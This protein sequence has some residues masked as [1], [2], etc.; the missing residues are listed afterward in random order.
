MFRSQVL[1]SSSHAIHGIARAAACVAVFSSVVFGGLAFAQ[2]R[3][4][5]SDFYTIET[6][7]I[8]PEFYLEVGAIEFLPDGR[9]A[10]SSRRGDVVMFHDPLRADASEI[11][12]TLFASG[13]HEVLG[14]SW[15]DGAL[16]ATQRG[17]VTRMVDENQ[18]GRADLLECVSDGWQIGGDYHEYAFGSKFD[19]NGDIWVVLCLTGSFS[20]DNAYRG[21]CLRISPDGTVTPTCSGIRS[22]GGIGFNAAGDV[23]YT[24]NQGPWNGTCSLKHL[25]PGS[26]QG[27]PGGNRWY[28]LTD[29]I[30][31]RPLDPVDGSRFVVEAD[32]IPEYEPPCV[33]FPYKKMGQS[34]SGIACDTTDGAFGPFAGQMFVGDQTFSTVMRVSLEQVRGHY[35]GACYPFLEGF[36]SG[37]LAVEMAK[38]GTMFVGGTNRGWGSRGNKPY[39]LERVR[40]TGETPFEVL[41]MS[42]RPDGFELS[43]TQ[44]VDPETAGR[45]E[46]YQLPTYT[47]LFQAAYGSPEVDHVDCQIDRVEVSDDGLKVRLFVDQLHRGHVHEL[48]MPGVTNAA[49]LPLLHDTA[50]YTLNYIPE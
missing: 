19:K 11:T 28:E 50:Y 1:A 31:A 3:P 43:F 38:D 29:A 34:A 2:D 5:E 16:Y 6:V 9:M 24:D 17:E 33:Q 22:P 45:P 44:P 12:S 27:H 49:G 42:A 39:A 47:Y 40:W 35:Q 13:L 37:T 14:L 10:A 32:R 7:P 26:F 46:S 15:R 21:W 23:F 41:E 36:G 8:P 4:T 20:S 48:H 30:G 25:R 18:D